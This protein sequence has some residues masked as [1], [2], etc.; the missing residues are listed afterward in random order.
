MSQEGGLMEQ[1]LFLHIP[2]WMYFIYLFIYFDTLNY[3]YSRLPYFLHIGKEW[4]G[5]TVM[6][7]IAQFSKTK[8]HVDSP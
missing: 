5:F 4:M 7:Q 6:I 1:V 2:G 8:R 3:V